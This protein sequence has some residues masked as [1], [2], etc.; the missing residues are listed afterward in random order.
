LIDGLK[1]DDD[2]DNEF[3]DWNY[4]AIYLPKEDTKRVL[5][6]HNKF[7][8][9]VDKYYGAIKEDGELLFKRRDRIE[10]ILNFEPSDRSLS[11][12]ENALLNFY[13]RVY[14]YYKRNIFDLPTEK[15]YPYYFIFLDEAD[16][17]FHPKWKKQ[18]V[19]SILEFLENF[20]SSIEAKVQVF[21]TTHDS[22]TLSDIPNYNIT[23]L[24]EEDGKRRVLS[25][26]EKPQKSFG[27]NITE[28][29]ADSFFVGNGLIGD[30]AKEKIDKTITWLK[31]DKTEGDSKYHE[32]LIR[33]IDEPIIQK[34]LSEMYD[35][36]TK[37]EISKELLKQQIEYLQEQYKKKFGL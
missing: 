23:Y 14:D 36:K 21:F 10:G 20:F 12:G 8:I 5:E 13:S 28:L 30:F 22:L 7:M 18:F 25:E 6:L 29:L 11:S 16:L 19:N 9:E 2:R 15:K 31:N 35:E 27:A 34:K 3:F 17:G 1:A 26:E 4:K 24:T 32:L 33:N 37:S